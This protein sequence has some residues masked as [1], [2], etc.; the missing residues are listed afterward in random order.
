MK[1]KPLAGVNLSNIL[2]KT[3]CIAIPA[4]TIVIFGIIFSFTVGHSQ[5]N[6]QAVSSADCDKP[7]NPYVVDGTGMTEQDAVRDAHRMAVEQAVVALSP[8]G[9]VLL[10]DDFSKADFFI[11]PEKYTQLT[12]IVSEDYRWGYYQVKAKFC[13]RVVPLKNSFDA[14]LAD[15]KFPRIMIVISETNTAE[16]SKES[17]SES[18]AATQFIQ[19]Q[20]KVVD[21]KI[22]HK[23]RGSKEVKVALEGDNLAASSLGKQYGA[24]VVVLGTA[25]S[26][27]ITESEKLKQCW[28]QVQARLVKVDSSDVIATTVQEAVGID[29]SQKVAEKRALKNAGGKIADDFTSKIV[30]QFTNTQITVV[31]AEV[32]FLDQLNALKD[33]FPIVPGVLSINQ[34]DF[35]NHVGKFKLWLQG[36]D[37]E[38]LAGRLDGVQL[39]NGTI[40]LSKVTADRI[41]LNIK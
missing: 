38:G 30:S 27:C 1:Q 17:I 32:N 34:R 10:T 40:Y 16:K 23:I 18:E 28:A 41:E 26:Q 15:R 12:Q 11:K 21:P 6:V 22:V 3:W 35:T 33:H 25:L 24:A 37:A 14:L 39:Q 9:T 29:L 8:A 2:K 31:V 13:V 7:T 19:Q 4:C 36:I 20:F 5:N